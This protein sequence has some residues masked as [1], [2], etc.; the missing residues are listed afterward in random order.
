[1][2]TLL[3]SALRSPES[4]QQNQD[5]E[6]SM[7]NVVME[8]LTIQDAVTNHDQVLLEIGELRAVRSSLEQRLD[9]LRTAGGLTVES[10]SATKTILADL[11]GDDSL[12]SV[13]LEDVDAYSITQEGLLD[14]IKKIDRAVRGKYNTL[15]E[16]VRWISSG[17]FNGQEKTTDYLT[18]ARASLSSL[19]E[20]RS[21]VRY[22][23]PA[24]ATNYLHYEGRGD[25]SSVLDGIQQTTSAFRSLIEIAPLANDEIMQLAFDSAQR[26]KDELVRGKKTKMDIESLVKKIHGEAMT[27]AER[28]SAKYRRDIRSLGGQSIA[29][30][31][32]IEYKPGRRFGDEVKVALNIATTSK[33]APP[34][35]EL[36]SLEELKSLIDATVSANAAI[37]DSRRTYEELTQTF[38]DVMNDKVF[39][40]H[41]GDVDSGSNEAIED[42]GVLINLIGTAFAIGMI[43]VVVPWAGVV[44]MTVGIGAIIYLAR[45][46]MKAI[47]GDY[48]DKG[49]FRADV[50]ALLD[51]KVKLPISDAIGDIVRVMTDYARFQ[52]TVVRASVMHIHASLSIYGKETDVPQE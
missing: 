50:N 33:N 43:S 15:L 7:L 21:G 31:R 27:E 18:T 29:G 34:T 32:T 28:V 52:N 30:G 51:G 42:V 20:I 40:R 36:P 25:A 6:R 35:L 49:M 38:I 10:I 3:T 19:S 47:N 39:D 48:R 16:S 12:A 14:G 8:Q 22:Q 11:F 23:S 41:V 45:M 26:V 2:S 37:A 5:I 13:S 9:D 1:M 46:L 44:G 24:L 17:L 4:T